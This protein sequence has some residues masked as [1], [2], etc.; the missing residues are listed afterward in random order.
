LETGKKEEEEEI[1]GI[2]ILHVFSKYIY[3]YIYIYIYKENSRNMDF[4][5]KKYIYVGVQEFNSKVI[6]T[7][8]YA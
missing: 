6:R 4:F 5:L 3:I 7:I 8:L 1:L 2:T